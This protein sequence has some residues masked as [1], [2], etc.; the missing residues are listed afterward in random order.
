MSK[1][2][3]SANAV[4]AL[5]SAEILWG[6]NKPV[7]KLGLKTVPLPLYLAITVLGA[8]LLVAPMAIKNWK[9]MRRKD[10]GLL[11][12][13]SVISITLGNVAL[14]MGLERVPAVNASLIGL[15]APL[16]LFILSVEFLKEH[17]SLKTFAG[18]LIAFTGAA[19]V[20]GKPWASGGANQTLVTGNL[21]II[22][23]VLCDITGTLICKPI[24]KRASAYQVTFIHLLSGILPIAVFA[25]PYLYALSPSRAGKNGYVTMAFNIVAITLANCLFMYGLKHK[26][27]QEIGIFQ[28]LSPLATIVSAWFLLAEVPDAKIIIGAACIFVGIYLAETRSPRKVRV[29][30]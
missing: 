5:I 3:V 10:Y 11:I 4:L 8:A 22:L 6:V 23:G 27:A 18:I 15:F 24:L 28:Y 19:I 20:V 21:F 1:T 14:L 25:V 9:P 7:I 2:K 16:L 26:K 12:V 13:G 29:D 30:I 17:M